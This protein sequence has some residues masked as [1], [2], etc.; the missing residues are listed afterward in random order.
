MGQMIG[1]PFIIWLFWS[2]FEFGNNDQIF[3]IIGLIGLI[4]FFTKYFKIEF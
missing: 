2:S 4:S 1:I 3:A